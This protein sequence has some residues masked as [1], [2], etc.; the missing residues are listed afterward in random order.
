MLRN[1]NK[2]AYTSSYPIT[3][4]SKNMPFVP[5][6]SLGFVSFKYRV[7]KSLIRIISTLD[8]TI[9]L[10]FF[11]SILWF[12]QVAYEA[13]FLQS[14]LLRELQ[15]RNFDIPHHLLRYSQHLLELIQQQKGNLILDKVS[16]N[17]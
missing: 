3:H 4:S 11:T 2:T 16:I 7:S 17:P 12:I 6:R 13:E 8:I 14:E 1:C 5:I 15:R 10:C 9:K